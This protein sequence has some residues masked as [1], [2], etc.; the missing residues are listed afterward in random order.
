LTPMYELG[1]GSNSYDADNTLVP[2]FKTGERLST[3]A[4]PQLDKMLED[5]R[6]ELDAK[7]R[8]A[9]YARAL[10]LIHDEA[11]WLFLFQYEDLYAT[12]KRLVWTARGDELIFCDE[13]KLNG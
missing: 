9:I 6:F 1:W 2:L 11:P 12:S 8:A 10:A 13:M 3:Y 5:A 7:K 4:N